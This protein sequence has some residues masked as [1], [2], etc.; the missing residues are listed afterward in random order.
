MTVKFRRTLSLLLASLMVVGSASFAATAAEADDLVG[1]SNQSYLESY[2]GNA[3]GE[4]G[5]GST[6]SPSQTTF[7]T[8][9]PE[10]SSVKVKLY[11]TG[12]DSEK[13]A[14]EIGVYD[15]TKNSSTGVWSCSLSGDH[16]NEY[17]TYIVNVKGKT[18]ETQDIYAKAVGVNGNR[19]MVVDLDSTDPQG[20]DSDRHV[21]FEN[22][23]EAVVWEIHVRDFSASESSGVSYENSGKYLAFTEAGTTLNGRSGDIATGIDYLVEQGINCVQLMPVYDFQSVD[24]TSPSATNRNWGYDPQNYNAPEGSYSTNPYD[25]NVRITEFKQMIQAL[26]DRGISVV[27]DVVY[28]HTYNTSSSFERTVPGY[29]YRMTNGSTF[30]NGSG[31]GNETA[32]DK[33]MYRKFMVESC[34]YW[35]EEYHI[36]GFRFDLM[37]LHDVATMNAIRSGLDSLYSDGTGKKILMY[38]EPWTGGTT[39]NPDPIYSWQGT[40]ISRLDSRVG[41]FGD[42][43]RDAIKGDTD[44]IGKGFVQGNTSANTGKIVS[45]VKGTVYSATSPKSPAQAV[46]YAD[47]HDNLIM[48]DK[49]VKSN[50]SS[51]YTGTNAEFQK[52]MK[53]IYTLLL[54]SQGIPF[55]TAGSEFGRTKK[56]DHNSYISPDSINAIDWNRVKQMSGLASYYKGLLSI[57]KNYSALH[58][59]YIVTP[60]FQSSYGDVVAYTYTNSKSGEW[61]KLAVL[62]NG[63]S[64]AYSITLDGSGWKVVAN[65]TSAGLTSLGDVSGNQYSIPAKGCAVLVDS[66][67]FGNLKP[68]EEFGTLTVNHVDTNGTLLKTQTAKYKA[69]ATYRATPDKDLLFDYEL[70]GTQGETSGTVAAGGT[71]TVTFT[72][73]MSGAGSGYVNVSHVDASGKQLAEPVKTRCKIGD[74]FTTNPVSIAGYQLDT[75]RLPANAGGTFTGTVDVK[76]VYVPLSNTTTT[77]HYKNTNNWSTVRCYAYYTNAAGATVELNGKWDTAKVM[78]SEGNNWYTATFS[79]PMAYVLFH[80]GKG[81]AGSNTAQD[82]GSVGYCVIGESW[83]ENGV[84]TFNTKVVTSHVDVKTGQKIA[85]DVV[86]N[87]DGVKSTDKYQTAPLAG[88]TDAIIPDNATGYYSAGIVNVVYYYGEGGEQ[89]TTAPAP[90]EKPTEAPTTVKPTEAPTTAKPTEKPT[91]APTTAKP[92]EPVVTRVLVGDVNFD[93]VINVVDATAIQRIA[94]EQV[95]PTQAAKIAGDVDGNGIGTVVDA[96]LVQRYAAGLSNTGNAGKYVDGPVPPVPP[97][98]APTTVI[99]TEK[100]TVAP[101]TQAPTQAPT[102]KPTEAPTTQAPTQAPTEKPTDPPT[103]SKAVYLNASAT[104]SGT[105]DWYA[106]TWTTGE[107]QWIK[108]EGD[109]SRVTFSGEI[110]TSILFVRLPKGETPCWDPKNIWNK[111]DDLTVQMGGTFVTSGWNNDLMLGSWS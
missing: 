19:S 8:W 66:A 65:G 74:S 34:K 90:T 3:Y 30:S 5:L 1:Y 64:Q 93:G 85:A 15:M 17:Y 100:P 33:Q 35:A 69:G 9:S 102:Q 99:P 24:E 36:D 95:V 51:D 39:L 75:S 25:G 97:T 109:A 89:P 45:G 54:T 94:A 107:G 27:M 57:R 7:K 60:S 10:A 105:E 13:G 55:M 67:S 56:G 44:G 48:W 4:T 79:A 78:T 77:V 76:Y 41:A 37:G 61:N 28:N 83:I 31:C 53:E 18:N 12:S 87:A 98:E 63:G 50:G 111:T 42:Q 84:E 71:Y 38:G 103:P 22:A 92:T 59:S 108:G 86:T 20:W 72:Y 106:W 49:I 21:V 101:T 23:G 80:N 82:P 11:K 46:S 58:S 16:K 26:H 32:S 104:C 96:T 29:Y 68:S 91:V 70:I 52:Q 110:G 2:A 40:G 88:R 73:Q 43:Y 81:T 14:G 62:V 47:A 6:Y